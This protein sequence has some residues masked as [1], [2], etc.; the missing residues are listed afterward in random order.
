[1]SRHVAGAWVHTVASGTMT[2]RY[3]T[4]LARKYRWASIVSSMSSCVTSVA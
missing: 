1:M 4:V 2:I 3:G